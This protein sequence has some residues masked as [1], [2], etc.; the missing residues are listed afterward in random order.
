L[1]KHFKKRF[2]RP[3]LSA[4]EAARQGRAARLAWERMPEAGA[5]VAFLNTHQVA[6]GG[7]PIDLAIA[8]E[9]G[10]RAVEAAI[11]SYVPA[12]PGGP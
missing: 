7:R 1:N 5:A 9:T 2:D 3:R 4:D 10:L 6:L 11:A 12:P 8:S